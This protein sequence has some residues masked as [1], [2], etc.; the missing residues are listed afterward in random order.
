MRSAALAVVVLA[1]VAGCGQ[2][3]TSTPPPNAQQRAVGDG[4]VRLVRAFAADHGPEFCAA[5]TPRARQLASV[6]IAGTQESCPAA[7]HENS[8]LLHLE[9][10]QI[11][12]TI[13]I[14]DVE[15]H[16]KQATINWT[17]TVRG[18]SWSDTAT[19]QRVGESWL[20]DAVQITQSG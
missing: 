13:H 16:N 1:L 18:K 14:D 6:N 12:K 3:P 10:S 19:A 9:I 20:Y 8:G 11:A 17:A 7:V 2:A 4:Y 15:V 5:L